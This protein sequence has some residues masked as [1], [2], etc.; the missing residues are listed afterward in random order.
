[1]KE[2]I[3]VKRLSED[4][5]NLFQPVFKDKIIDVCLDNNAW[6]AG[7]F[8]R[9]IAHIYFNINED[10]GNPELPYQRIVNYFKQGGDIDIFTTTRENLDQIEDIVLDQNDK[11]EV[12]KNFNKSYYSSPFALNFL[13]E[14]YIVTKNL[15][16]GSKGRIFHSIQIVNKF[17]FETIKE[18]FDSFDFTNCKYAIRKHEDEYMLYYSNLAL[19]DDKKCLLNICHT[20]SPFL[21][22]RIYKYCW[23][24]NLEVA[25]TQNNKEM[26]KSFCLK[27]LTKNWDVK[28]KFYSENTFLEYSAKNLHKAKTMS[29]E[30]LSLFIGKINQNI[31]I[32]IPQGYGYYIANEIVDWATNE[33]QFISNKDTCKKF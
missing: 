17:F 32:M 33:I 14:Q 15:Y 16:S 7:G 22:N 23:K 4:F 11:N 26:L 13:P 24:N 3:K 12:K 19:E 18:C 29:V 9:K 8:A 10:K 30:D 6:I 20:N 21:G 31:N 1:M 27:L 5:I 2:V 28:F 25:D